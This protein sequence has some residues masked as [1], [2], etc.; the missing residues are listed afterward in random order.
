MSETIE[1]IIDD[2]ASGRIKVAVEANPIPPST[3]ERYMLG[4]SD[5]AFVSHD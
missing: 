3:P 5:T 2:I 4:Y 1:K